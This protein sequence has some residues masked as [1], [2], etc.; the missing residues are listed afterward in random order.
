MSKRMFLALRLKSA[1]KSVAYC[2]IQVMSDG[3]LTL[4][5]PNCRLHLSS[6]FFILI[7][8]RLERRYM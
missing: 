6:A 2:F 8:Y 1:H 4:S 7:T 3:S 5:A